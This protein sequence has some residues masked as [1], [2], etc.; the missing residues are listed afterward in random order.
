MANKA[1]TPPNP[2]PSNQ[3]TQ[4]TP[5]VDDGTIYCAY[6]VVIPQIKAQKAIFPNVT[7][8]TE[9]SVIIR[10]NNRLSPLATIHNYASSSV[11]LPSRNHLEDKPSDLTHVS[12]GYE[13]PSLTTA[14]TTTP[15]VLDKDGESHYIPTKKKM[16]LFD[17]QSVPVK[18]YTHQMQNQRLSYAYSGKSGRQSGAHQPNQPSIANLMHLFIAQGFCQ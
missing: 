3:M 2:L 6:D 11:Q 17:T 18:H 9:K 4:S 7:P 8:G 5:T 13:F 12:D 10:D 1:P 14:S 15:V 16:N